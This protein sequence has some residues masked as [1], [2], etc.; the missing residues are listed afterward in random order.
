MPS[1]RPAQARPPHSKRPPGRWPPWSTRSP[2]ASNTRRAPN[3]VSTGSLKR[4]HA[5]GRRP[6]AAAPRDGDAASSLAC[7]AAEGGRHSERP[8]PQGS[9][10]LSPGLAFTGP[11]RP[12]DGADEQHQ[13]MPAPA[14]APPARSRPPPGSRRRACRTQN[15]SPACLRAGAHAHRHLQS[16]I[17]VRGPSS[18]DLRGAA[19]DHPVDAMVVPVEAPVSSTSATRARPGDRPAPGTVDLGE[20]VLVQVR[21]GERRLTSTR[22]PGRMR[23]YGSPRSPPP[24]ASPHRSRPARCGRRG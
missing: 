17:F 12:G 13:R 2:S 23:T 3:L 11:S 22:P 16:K 1:G 14:P 20:A 5:L 4:T 8:P 21:A 24:P 19:L 10:A 7:A 18:C 6:R 9:D 15:R